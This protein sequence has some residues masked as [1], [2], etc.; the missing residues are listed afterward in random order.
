MIVD[1]N[2]TIISHNNKPKNL[3][4]IMSDIRLR[5]L[6]SG[7]VFDAILDIQLLEKLSSFELGK[8]LLANKG[9][10]GYW[11]DYILTYPRKEKCFNISDFEK[12]ILERLPTFC[13]TQQRFN[14]F[15]F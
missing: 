5:L 4:M 9:L 2:G 12:T 10:N 8:F 11:T 6:D 1:S 15:L 13:A 3:Q 14:I 7:S